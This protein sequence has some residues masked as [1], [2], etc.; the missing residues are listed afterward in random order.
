MANLAVV[1]HWA[2]KDC[3]SWEIEEL[4]QWNERARV[5]SEVSK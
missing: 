3:E 5:R 4:M 1:F 2:P